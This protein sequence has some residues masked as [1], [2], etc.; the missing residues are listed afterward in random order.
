MA[1]MAKDMNT[2]VAADTRNQGSSGKDGDK[3]HVVIIGSGFGGLSAARAFAGAEDIEVTLVSTVGYHLFQP[4]LYQVATGTLS[5]G[6]IA[7]LTRMILEKQDNVATLL[8]TVTHVDLDTRTLAL[9]S[10]GIDGERLRTPLEY[11]S[12]I[13]AAGA[14]QSYFGNDHF[15][16]YAPG[17]KTI[18]D[19]LEI[20]SRIV[21]AFER[22]ETCDDP[23]ERR[24]L[25]TFIVVGGGPT[26]VEM[27]GQIGELAREVFVDAYRNID[28]S[29]AHVILVDSGSEI[30]STFG[31]HLGGHAHK[32]LSK[33]GVEVLNNTRVVDI[34]RHGVT[35]R[36]KETGETKRIPSS[37]K[38]WGAGVEA[39][40]LA[41]HVAAASGANVDRAGRVEVSPNLTLPGHPEV[42]CVGD[43]AAVEGVPGLAQGAIQGGAYAAERVMRLEAGEETVADRPPFKYKD[44][45]SMATVAKFSAVADLFGKARVYGVIGWLIWLFVHLMGL[46][47]FSNRFLVFSSW[48]FQTVGKNRPLLAITNQMLRGREAV[49]E[50]RRL[51][52]VQ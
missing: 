44:L 28:T 15:E 36:R 8:G 19:A 21:N 37:C 13:I 16:E 39:A 25:L 46:V 3:H 52:E 33:L 35:V 41:R 20:R 50:A 40:P 34:D 4:L 32:T 11:D 17:L 47:G 26:G 45:G 1:D 2:D 49:R 30:L 29:E 12:L 48:A 6:Q 18:D 43:M 27:A 38:V 31:D 9:E 24:R 42:F 7:P 10:P 22:A 23:E 14:N 51:D 5:V